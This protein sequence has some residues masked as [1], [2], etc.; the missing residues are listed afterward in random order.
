MNEDEWETD[1]QEE[2]QGNEIEDDSEWEDNKEDEIVE[3]ENKPKKLTKSEKK[4][5]KALEKV[6]KILF[7]ICLE[8]S[9]TK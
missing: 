3:E 9:K 2:N 1:S 6:F 4:K 5:A 7:L 8:N